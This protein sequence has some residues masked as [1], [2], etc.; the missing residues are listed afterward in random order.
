M[1]R[2]D[3]LEERVDHNAEQRKQPLAPRQKRRRRHRWS[4]RKG[5]RVSRVHRF[6]VVFL[7]RGHL[8]VVVVS[9]CRDR[10]LGCRVFRFRVFR[11]VSSFQF[12]HFA[13]MVIFVA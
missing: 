5:F 12:L 9:L 7:R 13:C 8:V 6:H 11:I 1:A 3:A 4:L 10:G 2:E